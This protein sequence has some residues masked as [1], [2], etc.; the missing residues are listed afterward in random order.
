MAKTKYTKLINEIIKGVGGKENI[1]SVDHC[2]TRL[3]FILAD[4]NKANQEKL[5]VTEGVLQIVKAG[6]QFQIVIGQHVAD[7]YDELIQIQGISHK[8]EI[9]EKPEK[10]K[11]ILDI[12]MDYAQNIIFPIVFTMSACA[13][14]NGI[15]IIARFTGLWATDSAIYILL[16]AIGNAVIYMMPIFLGYTTAKKSG[17]DVVV[18]MAIGA[19]MVNPNASGVDINVFGQVINVA[20][21]STM[22]P[23]IIVVLLATPLYKF[24]FKKLPV[25]VRSFL[26]PAITLAVWVPIGFLAIGPV[27]NYVGNFIG[28]GLNMMIDAVPVIAGFIA[29]GTYSLC[30]IFG[31]HGAITMPFLMN[32]L[33]GIPDSYSA[34]R[35]GV[36]FAMAAM[37]LAIF[38]KTKKSATK[39]VAF[40]AFVSG[41]F[42]VTEPA[43]YG[44][45]IQSVKVFVASSIGAGLGGALAGL[46]GCKAWG[47]GSGGVFQVTGYINPENPQ[48]TLF[49]IVAVY[50]VS[51]VSSFI[52]TWLVFKDPVTKEETFTNFETVKKYNEKNNKTDALLED[53]SVASPLE[54]RIIPLCEVEDDA[55]ATETLGKGIAI[56]PTKGEVVAPFDCTVTSLFSTNHAIGLTSDTGAELL[57]HIGLDTVKLEGKYFQAHVKKDEKVKKG[58]VLVTFDLDQIKKEGYSAVTPIII[59][60][61]GNYA[62]VVT[63]VN[64]SQV[65]V[66]DNLLLVLNQ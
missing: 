18:G 32:V 49:A 56:D 10:K 6:G 9:E 59:L 50:A 53:I 16:S 57:I 66:G 1:K 31:L 39:N 4:E 34:M 40:P 20:Y 65:H 62:D 19:A 3:R 26:A 7:V 55:F 61:T 52:L 44:L 13:I 42:G 30:V 33:A 28:A 64:T 41:M 15:N 5:K 60:N 36:C 63:E 2:M 35:S 47:I 21:T 17:M 25:S 11:K 38:I 27:V 37:A 43:L 23:V 12:F 8:Q 48:S 45:A 22:L 46:L 54:G 14:I 29:A 24:A 51:F 58:T